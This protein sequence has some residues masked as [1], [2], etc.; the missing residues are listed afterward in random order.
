M[1]FRNLWSWLEI[2]TTRVAVI[3]MTHVIHGAELSRTELNTFMTWTSEGYYQE[4][5]VNIPTT[6]TSKT[7]ESL[8][9]PA[10]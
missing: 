8:G 10:L 7:Q 6:C 4:R 3:F 5:T 9:L 2:K 1:Y